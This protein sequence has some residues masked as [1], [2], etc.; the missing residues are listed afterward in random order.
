MAAI[1]L[2]SVD[3]CGFGIWFDGILLQ[4][5]LK[6][7]EMFAKEVNIVEDGKLIKSA[8]R[9]ATSSTGLCQSAC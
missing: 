7:N 9:F 6:A 2:K 4:E 1:D 5:E 8:S 3:L